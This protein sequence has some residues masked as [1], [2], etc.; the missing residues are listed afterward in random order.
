VNQALTRAYWTGVWQLGEILP[1]ADTRAVRAAV[2]ALG[3]ELRTVLAG[4]HR[5]PAV[6][7]AS[8]DGEESKATPPRLKE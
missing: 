2:K 8:A 6:N 1:A 5:Q 3:Q 7:G 4:F